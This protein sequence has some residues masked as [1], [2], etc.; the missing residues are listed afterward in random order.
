[1]EKEEFEKLAEISF[2]II[3]NVGT[4]KSM[5]IQAVQKAKEGDFEGAEKDI[6][7]GD[8][9]FV[10]GHHAHADL[11]AKEAGGEAVVPILLLVHAEDQLMAAETVK[12]LCL[13]VI[14]LYK[15]L[16]EGGK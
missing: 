13:E 15:K 12:I 2:Q 3:A 1:M 10:N 8:S 5:Y 6:D 16:A 9:I 4:A 7:E 11:V 14:E